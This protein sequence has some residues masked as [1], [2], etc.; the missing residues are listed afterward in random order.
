M[1]VLIWSILNLILL[2]LIVYL[3]FRVVL[4]FRS[5]KLTLNE[6]NRQITAQNEILQEIIQNTANK[7]N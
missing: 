7:N 6:M 1:R 5:I 2:G 3:I 4:F